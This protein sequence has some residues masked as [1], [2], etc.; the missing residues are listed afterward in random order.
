MVSR[1][2]SRARAS[3]D[4]SPIGSSGSTSSMPVVIRFRAVATFHLIG[5]IHVASS[6]E[7]VARDEGGG[8]RAHAGVRNLGPDTAREEERVQ[9]SPLVSR[10]DALAGSVSPRGYDPV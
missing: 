9:S 10:A 1:R 6:L 8:Q 3:A 7:I 5:K 4:S 2:R